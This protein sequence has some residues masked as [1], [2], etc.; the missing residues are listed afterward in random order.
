MLTDVTFNTEKNKSNCSGKFFQKTLLT[1]NNKKYLSFRDPGRKKFQIT[2]TANS[3]VNDILKAQS[4]FL[5]TPKNSK[6]FKLNNDKSK[7]FVLLTSL[8]KLPEIEN[9][10]IFKKEDLIDVKINSVS[11]NDIINN[12]SNLL[13]YN[14]SEEKKLLNRKIISKSSSKKT[15]RIF[16]E[17]M[18]DK[19]YDD[20]EIQMKKKFKNKIFTHDK[21]IP[22]KIIKMSQVGEFW[23]GVFDYCCPLFALKKYKTFREIQEKRNKSYKK[24]NYCG[25]DD[26]FNID[27]KK[28]FMII[29]K[30]PK[31]YKYEKIVEVKKINKIS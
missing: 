1:R 18:K 8:Y 19:F 29:R 26:Y 17:I 4:S 25:R 23:K 22:D 3:S 27:L 24:Q 30:K 31:I 20:V 16:Y 2:K 5:S 14:S 7:D 12:N 28:D 15:N 11:E 21:S 6:T 9:K 13:S 10:S